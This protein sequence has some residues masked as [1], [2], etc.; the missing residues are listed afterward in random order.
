MMYPEV[1]LL[2]NQVICRVGMVW[3]GN[4]NENEC[5]V[6]GGGSEARGAKKKLKAESVPKT[7]RREL[8]KS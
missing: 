8:R 5:Q 4:E 7:P 1:R 6:Y 2:W 3:K